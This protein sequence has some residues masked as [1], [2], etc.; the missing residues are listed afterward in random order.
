VNRDVYDV[1][2][3]QKTLNDSLSNQYNSHYVYS[4]PGLNFRINRDKFNLT[5]GSALQQTRLKGDL[6]S[7]HE[8]INRLFQAVLPV[9]HFNFDFSNF[10][11]LRFDY[12]T[13]MQEPDIQQLQPVLNNTDQLNQ[14]VGNPF[15]R[16]AYAH[17][18]RTNFTLFNPSSFMNF[19]AIINGNYTANAIV[20]SQTTTPDF[21][22]ITKPVNVKYNMSLSG[23][24]NV[25]IP[26]NVIHSRFNLG[27]SYSTSNG[28]NLTNDVEN[29]IHQQTLGG[30]LRYNY[31][32]KE[33]LI[34]DLSSNLSHQ[35]SKYSFN[36][37][38]NQTYFNKTYSA[39]VNVNFLKNYAFNTELD[40]FV[41]ASTTTDFHQSIPLWNMSVSRFVLKNKTG[42][43][44][45]GVNN[46]LNRSLSV[47]QS[48]STNYLQQQTTNNLGR[49]FM[50]SFTYALNKQL[51]PMGEGR[52][53][54]GGGTRMIIRQ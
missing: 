49:F 10:K 26:V 2:N 11:R 47:T 3:E 18:I 23:N 44:K 4:R 9:L 12:T 19:F 25:G 20:N 6:L 43:I 50:V 38:Q 45:V 29:V 42:E 52:R 14:T 32:F 22:R 7:K 30:T 35:E 31:A 48:A 46:L 41:Y 16:P 27:P 24:F 15:L 8:T 13:A 5:V 1:K 40:Y 17:Q 21:I 53:R 34:V 54:N 39:E 36:A 37:Q 28:I 33:I 51:N